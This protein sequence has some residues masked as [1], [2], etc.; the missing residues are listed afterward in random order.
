LN[1]YKPAAAHAAVTFLF[2][3]AFSFPGLY[4]EVKCSL[5]TIFA[6]PQNS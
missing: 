2:V 4:R 6:L 5:P 3:I 1:G